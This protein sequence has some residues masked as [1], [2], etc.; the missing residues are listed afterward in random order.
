[1]SATTIQMSRLVKATVFPLMMGAKD[2]LMVIPV[3]TQWPNC[4]LQE[5]S[6]LEK[7]MWRNH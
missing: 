7:P 5:T 1:M 3:Q 2:H 4:G 6:N